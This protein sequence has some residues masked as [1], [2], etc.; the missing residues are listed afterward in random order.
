VQTA[1]FLVIGAGIAGASAA[2]ALAE[3]GSVLLLERESQPGYH[4]TGRSAALYF[5]S[6]GNRLVQ[7]LTRASGSFLKQPP[8]GFAEHPILAPRGVLTIARADQLGLLDQAARAA[9][10][11][12]KPPAAIDG[13]AAERLLPVLR[14]GHVAGALFQEDPQDIDVHALHRGFLRSLAAR[15]GRLI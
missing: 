14:P 7:C 15:G 13:K 1:D 11:F 2:F 10:N 8:V 4:S 6:Y 9:G 3:H 5:E 12:G